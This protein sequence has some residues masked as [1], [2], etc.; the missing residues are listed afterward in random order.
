MKYEKNIVAALGFMAMSSFFMVNVQAQEAS[1]ARPD[2]VVDRPGT[3]GPDASRPD[4]PNPADIEVTRENYD[5]VVSMLA[6]K[7]LNREQ[8]KRWINASL[9][10]HNGRPDIPNP[11]DFEVTRENYDR[12]VS[13][14]AGKGLNRKQIQRWINASLGAHADRP[15]RPMPTARVKVAKNDVR[16]ALTDRRTRPEPVVR[17]VRQ[18]RPVRVTTRPVQRVQR[19]VKRPVRP[20]TRRTGG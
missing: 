1:A 4:I 12:V 19:P 6:G 5:R 8:I 13:M 9:G 18:V 11:A 7:G 14:L 15:D 16:A 2:V 17:T 20:Q 3:S 10:A